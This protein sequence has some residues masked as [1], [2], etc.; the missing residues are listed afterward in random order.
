MHPPTALNFVK[1][2]LLLFDICKIPCTA[3]SKHD[4]GELSRFLCELSVCDYYFVPKKPSSI[5]LAAL[6]TAI[7]NIDQLRLSY[8]TRSL[9]FSSIKT[10]ARLDLDAPEVLEC[11]CRLDEMY[12][13]GSYG[14]QHEDVMEERGPSPNFVGDA[15]TYSETK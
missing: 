14:G 3:A 1:H 15:P 11:R 7:D 6:L 12:R 4:V 8:N 13:Q 2:L 5:A 10:I 9:F